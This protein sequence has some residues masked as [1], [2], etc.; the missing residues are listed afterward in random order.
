MEIEESMP[1]GSGASISSLFP[2]TTG[3]LRERLCG[4]L[5]DY[6]TGA[7]LSCTLSS[8]RGVK[9]INSGGDWAD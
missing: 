4:L 5:P 6:E 9:S 1:P 8:S 7:F 2:L 3:L